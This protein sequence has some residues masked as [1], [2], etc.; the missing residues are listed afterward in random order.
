MTIELRRF[1]SKRGNGAFLKDVDQALAAAISA[2]D[3]KGERTVLELWLD[4]WEGS[5]AAKT[6]G[7]MER[8]LRSRVWRQ[9]GAWSLYKS[10]DTP[11]MAFTAYYLEDGSLVVFA[12]AFA[13]S[14]PKGGETAW[15]NSVIRPRLAEL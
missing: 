9:E 1:I 15:L 8:Y 2:G 4:Y 5:L 3:A 6:Q 13:Y 7:Q 11:C 14:Y 12:L 10:A